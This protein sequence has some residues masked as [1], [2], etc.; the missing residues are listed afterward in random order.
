MARLM[1]IAL[2]AAALAG[3]SASGQVDRRSPP[4]ATMVA[5]PIAMAIAGFD[6]DGD[7]RTTRAELTAGVA[8]SVAFIDTG[9]TGMLRYLDYADWALRFLGD[10]N[11]LP[12]PFDVDR[13]GDDKVSLAELQAAFAAAFDR[14]DLDHDG[15]AT[16]AELLT[17]RAGDGG[18]R[19]KRSSR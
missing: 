8:R 12:S 17:I 4:G 14:F 19:G 11:A 7:G 6:A 1:M 10:R 16:R 18:A 13:N 3:Q 5:E 2:I 9:R 15:V